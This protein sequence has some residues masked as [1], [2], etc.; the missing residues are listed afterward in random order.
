MNVAIGTFFPEVPPTSRSS[1]LALLTCGS[2]GQQ[3][4]QALLPPA[5]VTA[6]LEVTKTVTQTVAAAH[7]SPDVT[8]TQLA[9]GGP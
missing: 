8:P 5:P 2:G 6:V 7:S 3:A 1:Q 9:Q 4:V